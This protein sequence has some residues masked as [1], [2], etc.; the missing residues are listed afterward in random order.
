M[1]PISQDHFQQRW[2]GVNSFLLR[3]SL[4]LCYQ[5]VSITYYH[6][7]AYTSHTYMYIKF[8]NTFVYQ[9]IIIFNAKSHQYYR[10]LNIKNYQICKIISGISIENILSVHLVRLVDKERLEYSG[11]SSELRSTMWMIEQVFIFGGC[12]STY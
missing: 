4:L 5:S 11:F 3:N 10:R 12:L 8:F 2:I 1:K 9:C 6:T 7:R